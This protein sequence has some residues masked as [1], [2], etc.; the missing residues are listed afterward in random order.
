[1]NLVVLGLVLVDLTWFSNQV[2][3]RMP[4]QFFTPPPIVS[5]LEPGATVFHRGE[6]TQQSIARTYERISPAYSTRNALRPFSP[7]LWG[8]GSVLE[9]DVDETFLL[10]THDLLD[11]MIRRG[12]SGDPHWSDAFVAISNVRYVIDYKQANI[13]HPI[14]VTRVPIRGRFYFSSG[15]GRILRASE[16]S[17]MAAIDVETS[18][19]ALMSITITRHKYWR[20]LIDG[21][22]AKLQPA[23]LAYQALLIPAG[24]HHI[25]LRYRNPV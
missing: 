19:D 12:N 3:P 22:A 23:N 15:D 1:M 11:A 13:D 18:G 16:S 9:A 6:W 25:E 7:A 10:P 8:L 20:A 14:L 4:A 21:R 17:S 5:A 2:L 24:K